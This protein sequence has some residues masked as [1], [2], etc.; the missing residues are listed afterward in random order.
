M[1]TI[2]GTRDHRYD[3]YKKRKKKVGNNSVNEPFDPHVGQ[4][5]VIQSS[6]RFRVVNCGRRWGKTTLAVN[7]MLAKGYFHP[8]SRIVYVAPTFAQARDI[9]WRMLK[10]AAVHYGG[11]HKVNETRLELTMGDES[12]IWLRGMENYESLRG[13]GLD[14]LVAD[15]IASVKNWNSIWEQVL[16]ATL[17]DKEGDALFCSTPKG[18]N[19]WYDLWRMGQKG[20][21]KYNKTYESW[22]FPSWSNPV[23]SP[24]EIESS[25]AELAEDVFWQE[26]GAQ[27]K[28]F[29]GLVYKEFDRDKHVIND[30]D[31]NKIVSWIVGHDPGFHNPRAFHLTGVDADGVWYLVDELYKPGLT[32]PEFREEVI[33][34]LAS[35]KVDFDD[36]AMA[37][38]D[39]AHASDIME[40]SNMGMAF[41]PVKKES[42]EQNRSWVRYK[43][44]KFAERLRQGRYFVLKRCKKTIWEFENYA[45]ATN[46]DDQ[47]PDESPMKMNDHMMDAIGDSNAMYI[48]MFEVKTKK[49]WD[50]KLAGT[51]IKPSMPD[52]DDLLVDFTED[53]PDDFWETEVL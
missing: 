50:G 40:L 43:I 27:F 49:P 20:E 12:E 21:E 17:M 8:K 48:H 3:T 45:W 28:R 7:E 34:I 1:P 44:D 24:A 37:T 38:M 9:A 22:S 32:N 41:L 5:E 15:E 31:T 23:L 42:G 14:F 33:R 10:D 25:K 53:K 26:W 30:V 51:F 11:A 47:N 13:I 39:S 4:L 29:T 36:L 6:A 19:H 35:Y 52:E 46:K 2:L 18:Y 16:R